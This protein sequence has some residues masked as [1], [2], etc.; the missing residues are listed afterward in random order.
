MDDESEMVSFGRS[1][2]RQFAPL[3]TVLQSVVASFLSDSGIAG[4]STP[5]IVAVEGM[6]HA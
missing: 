2:I 6:P 1:H 3:S 5:A 4:K